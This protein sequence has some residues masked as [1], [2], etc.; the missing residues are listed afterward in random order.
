MEHLAIITISIL[1]LRTGLV[2]T[3]PKYIVHYDKF[4]NGKNETEHHN[5]GAAIDAFRF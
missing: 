4:R 2:I 5:T 1:Q 3:E